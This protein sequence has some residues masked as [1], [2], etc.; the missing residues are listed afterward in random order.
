MEE[1]VKVVASDHLLASKEAL[2]AIYEERHVLVMVLV[3]L[4]QQVGWPV[5]VRYHDVDPLW[6]VV[7]IETPKGQ[8]C[9]HL[10][11]DEIPGDLGLHDKEWDGTDSATKYRR[12]SQLAHHL[13]ESK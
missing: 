7:Y 4:A 12:L 1:K 3:R 10:P 11:A 8:V 9:F 5:G 13:R 2:D 6:P